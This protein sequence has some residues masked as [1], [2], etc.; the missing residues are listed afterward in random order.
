[1]NDITASALSRFALS[2]LCTSIAVVQAYEEYTFEGYGFYYYK[3]SYNDSTNCH[4]R[5]GIWRVDLATGEEEQIF[6]DNSGRYLIEKC[7]LSYH[8]K[9]LVFHGRSIG[10][11][12]VNNDGTGYTKLSESVNFVAY[13]PGNDIYWSKLGYYL[14]VGPRLR[15]YDVLT[16]DYEDLSFPGRAGAEG[17]FAHYCYASGDGT[18]IWT[19]AG[20]VMLSWGAKNYNPDKS[21]TYYVVTDEGEPVRMF[22]RNWWGHGETI[23]LDGAHM[24]FQN[25]A[26]H[27]IW[28]IRFRDGQHIGDV[29]YKRPEHTNEYT[30]G[31]QGDKLKSITN[32]NEWIY[33]YYR[34]HIIGQP[35]LFDTD[36]RCFMQSVWNWR[37][38]ERV[39]IHGPEDGT[40]MPR[41]RS[42]VAV[43]CA[44]IW[45]GYDL[46]AVDENRAYLVPYRKNVTFY[47]AR[48]QRVMERAVGIGNIDDAPLEGV[49][50]DVEPRNAASW[51]E[52]TA[53]RKTN[54]SI[55]VTLR[56]DPPGLAED[57]LSA[58]VTVSA[59]TARNTASFSVHTD[60]TMLPPPENFVA[61]HVNTTDSF[62]YPELTWE[63]IAE[64]EDGYSVE[65]FTPFNWNT[66]WKV[67]DTVDANTTRYVSPLCHHT[68]ETREGRY[69]IRGFT[70]D[71][72][73]SPYSAEGGFGV[74]HDSLVPPPQELIVEP[75]EA[76]SPTPE[77]WKPVSHT[78]SSDRSPSFTGGTIRI[79]R[80]DGRVVAHRGRMD[81]STTRLEF[82]LQTLMRGVLLVQR[83]DRS[84]NVRGVRRLVNALPHL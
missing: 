65:F 14:M 42:T 64:G 36:E 11:G 23:T 76:N 75:W 8:G 53:E 15:R 28:I 51:L 32:T 35:K 19:R 25:F 16:G 56:V 39:K 22:S 48:K 60:N 45:K 55:T 49:A 59:E 21:Q 13:P 20:Q 10:N 66:E 6:G 67:I 70:H 17:S 38:N 61:F 1:M 4:A 83:L 79:V 2:L 52:A 33:M 18:H 74:P 57:R 46:P 9:Q 82:P 12:M 63:D 5:D 68:N 27:G 30:F 73:L 72:L 34:P 58:E 54:S 47:T 40:W 69:R 29:R 62:A 3:E 71:G 81:Y 80:P 31:M 43:Q 50:V 44:G 37:T 78:P 7:A 24:L 84:G 77:R 41:C 26:H